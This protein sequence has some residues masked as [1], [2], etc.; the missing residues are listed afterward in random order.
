MCF[1]KSSRV[2]AAFCQLDSI[3]VMAPNVCTSMIFRDVSG[4]MFLLDYIMA[5]SKMDV[6]QGKAVKQQQSAISAL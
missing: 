3:G 2:L 6:V 4:I 1:T 5:R